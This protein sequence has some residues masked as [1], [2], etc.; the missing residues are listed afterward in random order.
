M[1][2][3]ITRLETHMEYVRRDF[4]EIKDSLKVLPTL[5]TK[6]DLAGSIFAGLG[7]GFAIMAIVIG[8]VIGGLGWLQSRVPAQTPAASAPLAP[9]AN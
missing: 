5:A 4:A 7:L 8:G 2:E 9:P 3:R 6:R 1:E